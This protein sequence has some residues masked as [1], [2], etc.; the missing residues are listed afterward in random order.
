[1]KT[2]P[3]AVILFVSFTLASGASW[4]GDD[5]EGPGLKSE[6]TAL[7]LGLDPIPGDSLFYAGEY[8]QGSVNLVVGAASMVG[9][10]FGISGL[11]CD[12]QHGDDG[13][14]I[15]AFVLT[16]GSAFPYLAMLIWDAFGGVDGVEEYNERAIRHHASIW[17][18]VQPSL[19]VTQEGA[20]GGV[21]ITF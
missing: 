21:R 12:N 4:A 20:F 14:K 13:C 15:Q 8:L 19:A 7:L 16:L 3:I 11:F 6:T 5:E 2:K 10:G 17:N 18:R 9:L 1:M